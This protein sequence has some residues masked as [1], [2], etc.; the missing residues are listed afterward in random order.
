MSTALEGRR[1]RFTS[2]SL[3]GGCFLVCRAIPLVP[4]RA[5]SERRARREAPAARGGGWRRAPTH[6]CRGRTFLCLCVVLFV[7]CFVCVAELCVERA[8]TTVYE[9]SVQRERASETVLR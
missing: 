9:S 7:E 1:R 5:C 2:L 8:G 4:S 6:A 3:N